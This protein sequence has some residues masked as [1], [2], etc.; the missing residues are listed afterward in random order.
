MYDSLVIRGQKA[1]KDLSLPS[2]GGVFSLFNLKTK[3]WFF[4]TFTE[5]KVK[6]GGHSSVYLLWEIFIDVSRYCNCS[7]GQKTRLFWFQPPLSWVFNLTY[8]WLK[9]VVKS[10]KCMI[11]LRLKLLL[12][13]AIEKRWGLV[14]LLRLL[15]R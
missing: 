4:T 13:F 2:F 5:V 10:L 11:H 8:N 6:L 12:H 14:D 9:V 7:V 3:S 15:F 1:T